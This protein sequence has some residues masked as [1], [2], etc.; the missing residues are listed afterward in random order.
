MLGDL[1]G[2]R[3]RRYFTLGAKSK[4][5]FVLIRP[6]GELAGWNVQYPPA[7]AFACEGEFHPGIGLEIARARLFVEPCPDLLSTGS[8]ET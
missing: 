4:T 8:R 3:I 7:V 6:V 2:E 5:E 1:F